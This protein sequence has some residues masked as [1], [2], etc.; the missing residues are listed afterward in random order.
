ME[1]TRLR[2]RCAALEEALAS[3]RLRLA[4]AARAA[5]A[6]EAARQA[7]EAQRRDADERARAAAG[8]V[9]SGK[10]GGADARW[11]AEVARA[12]DNA[13]AADARARAAAQQL[14]AVQAAYDVLLA[15]VHDGG[16]SAGA[17]AGGPPGGAGGG[18][19]PPT[20]L[21]PSPAPASPRSVVPAFGAPDPGTT[22]PASLLLRSPGT[23]RCVPGAPG[24]A[25]PSMGSCK[26]L[27]WPFHALALAALPGA[28]TRG[29][30]A[31]CLPCTSR[32]SRP[33]APGTR[34]VAPRS[35]PKLPAALRGGRTPHAEATGSWRC[36]E[37]FSR[38]PALRLPS[39]R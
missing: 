22:T 37:V 5:E 1:A 29:A 6:S 13:A 4:A 26:P 19:Y 24:R 34:P 15:A 21:A 18:A 2:A 9:P 23:H 17:P 25:G 10:G 31:R 3:E 39:F 36:R 27:T 11:A 32:P 20:P 8:L 16:A 35:G 28:T 38:Q 30:R 14:A 7:A 33:Q 12:E